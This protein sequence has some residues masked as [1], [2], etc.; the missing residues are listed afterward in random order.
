MDSSLQML[1]FRVRP[2]RSK[3]ERLLRSPAARNGHLVHS[4]LQGLATSS[5]QAVKKASSD[6]SASTPLDLRIEKG[7][8]CK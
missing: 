3:L 7:Q 1:V 2:L 4:Y 6:V 5:V 8:A